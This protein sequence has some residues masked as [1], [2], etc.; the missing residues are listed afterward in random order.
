V[1]LP[2][3][4]KWSDNLYSVWILIITGGIIV[5][6]SWETRELRIETQKSG[7]Q[8]QRL[9]EE[10]HLQTEL[11]LLPIVYPVMIL[12]SISVYNCGNSPALNI[13]VKVENDLTKPRHEYFSFNFYKIIFSGILI[14]ND[15][16]RGYGYFHATE[17]D[18]R[19]SSVRELFILMKKYNTTIKIYCENIQKK[20]YVFYYKAPEVE[21]D[22][23]LGDTQPHGLLYNGYEIIN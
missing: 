20:K 11:Q 13:E 8:A 4:P 12:D 16:G 21:K 5:W 19:I 22:D 3:T 17:E 14:K 15:N 2:F 7:E 10:I 6:Y 9:G 1:K 23:P 18:K